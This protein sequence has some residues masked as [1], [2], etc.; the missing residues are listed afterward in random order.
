MPWPRDLK[1]HI[2]GHDNCR[3]LQV[4]SCERLIEFANCF[5]EKTCG[6]C[7]VNYGPGALL[8]NL[9]LS[10]V[11]ASEQEYIFVPFIFCVVCKCTVWCVNTSKLNYIAI[12]AVIVQFFSSSSFTSIN[13]LSSGFCAN[14]AKMSLP[15]T[16]YL[17]LEL[18]SQKTKYYNFEIYIQFD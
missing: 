10:C 13:C 11:C 1:Q 16:K 17:L 14:V 15:S 9:N 12:S 4:V 18:I 6:F 2:T 3:H 7:L 5:D 8:R